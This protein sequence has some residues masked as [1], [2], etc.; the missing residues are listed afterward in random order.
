MPQTN[1]QTRL[2]A[3]LVIPACPLMLSEDGH[4]SQRHQ[5]AVIRYYCDAGAGGLA[6]GVHSTQFAIRDPRHALLEPVLRVAA[7]ELQRAAEDERHESPLV[8]IAGICGDGA[9]AVA[10]ARL[11]VGLNY[12]AGLLSLT[13][14]VKESEENILE[15]CRRVAGEIPIVGFY[16]QPAVGG[17][18]YSFRFWRRFCEIPEVVAIKI[19]P[20]NRY[21]TLDVVRAVIESQRDDIALYTG[22]DDNIIVDLLTPLEFAGRRRFIVGGLLGQWGIWTRGAVTM[23]QQVKAARCEE[24]LQIDWLTRAAALTDANSAVFDA[25]NGFAGCIPGIMEVLRRQGLAPSARC[26]DPE[27]TL[28]AGQ[29]EELDRV[30]RDYPWLRDDDF[31][32]A[33]LH[34]WQSML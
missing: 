25:A 14:M 24:Q 1:W 2:Q 12:D 11:A 27:E 6:V 8:R 22:N 5:R 23:L 31:V 21:Q 15:H 26:L 18:A 19:A 33:N 34:R 32:A 3:G 7:E 16:L 10:E 9:Q 20:F 28:S 13:A 30:S 17:R 29:A 4:W